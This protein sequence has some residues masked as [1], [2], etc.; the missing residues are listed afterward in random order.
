[1]IL[2]FP[3]PRNDEDF[4]DLIASLIELDYQVENITR[5]GRSGQRQDG[6][7]V[8]AVDSYGRQLGYQ[9]KA[10]SSLTLQVAKDECAKA[11]T[12]APPLAR[13]VVAT[14][15]PRDARLQ[16][17]VRKLTFP[18]R[19]EIWFWDNINERLNR[20]PEIAFPYFTGLMAS[21]RAKSAIDHAHVLR[22]ALDRPAFLDPFTYERSVLDLEHALGDTLAFLKTGYL[23]TRERDI[24]ASALPAWKYEDDHYR[25]FINRFEQKLQLLYSWVQRRRSDLETPGR[26]SY[27]RASQKYIK[28]RKNLLDLANRTFQDLHISPIHPR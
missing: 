28:D 3:R 4:E 20:A 13:F 9:C 2:D 14:T 27:A 25:K 12:Y 11:S 23:Y 16:E 26:A 8:S 17:E 19:V 10:T 21:Y 15:A 6:V 24:V 22:Q 18:F 5:N 7:D 1:M